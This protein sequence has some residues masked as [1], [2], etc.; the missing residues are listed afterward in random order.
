MFD[1]NVQWCKQCCPILCSLKGDNKKGQVAKCKKRLG[2]TKG[3]VMTL[4]HGI[5][6]EFG[7]SFRL[8]V[9]F[10]R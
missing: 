2:L 4:L 6:Y 3:R 9:G 1:R 10:P 5:E 8:A 7:G